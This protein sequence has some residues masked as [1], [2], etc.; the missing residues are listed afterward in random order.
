MHYLDQVQAA[1]D[2]IE[3]H[4]E[5]EL[6]LEPG[7]VAR[8]AGL[9]QWHFQ[10][11][12]RALSNETLKSYI[13]SRRLSNAMHK[14]VSSNERVLE[15]A[16]AAGFES[17]E[18]FSRAF[19]KAFD[20]TPGEARKRDARTFLYRKL[21]IDADYL[22]HLHRHIASHEP[23][24][25]AMP[26]RCFVGMET[27]FF[28]IDS[29]RD[30]IAEKLPPLWD[31]FVPRMGEI[32]GAVPQW[33]F[34]IIAQSEA[35]T[36]K[37]RYLAACEVPEDSVKALPPG[38]QLW[39]LPARRYARFEHRGETTLL[40]NTVNYIYSSWLLSAPF[41]HS[42]DADV[43]E[44]GPDFQPGSPESRITYTIPLAD[45]APAI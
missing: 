32:E 12:F 11:I 23:Q 9:S 26:A 6:A 43:E 41:R 7:L 4:I 39:R 17:Q 10:R 27:T 45:D 19:K 30:N 20:M 38:M 25:I 24:I 18:S 13:R 5:E 28:S 2:Y 16:L 36:D 33:A 29:E 42:L 35:K 37:L 31:A 22:Q 8:Q 15:I 44:Y 34:G 21:R 14:L 40:N 3:R 1:I